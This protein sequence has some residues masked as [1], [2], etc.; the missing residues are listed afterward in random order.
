MCRCLRIQPSRFYAWLKAPLSRR[1]Q[2]DKRQT[3]LLKEA[4]L[5]SGKVY[6]HR[7]LHDELLEQGESVC[8]NRVARL[9]SS[10]GITAQIGYKRRPGKYGGK[11]SVV[12][13]NTL[14]QRFDVATPDTALREALFC[15]FAWCIRGF[16]C[17]VTKRRTEAVHSHALRPHPAQQHQHGH[18]GQGLM[19]FLPLEHI[20]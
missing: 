6:G 5:D 19:T 4:W 16:C 2:E 18:V 9:T 10:A 8:L 14:D 3:E 17:P 15:N 20:L 11:P 7:K 1:A 12:V 13:D